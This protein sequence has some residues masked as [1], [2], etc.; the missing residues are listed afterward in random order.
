MSEHFSLLDV[1]G[2]TRY[3][4]VEQ[5]TRI[6]LDRYALIGSLGLFFF[7]VQGLL[8]CF[9]QK[10]TNIAPQKMIVG[11]GSFPFGPFLGDMLN[12]SDF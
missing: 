12:F 7:A 10:K 9:L 5:W 8:I 11:R 2:F 1:I 3:T 4:V 6:L